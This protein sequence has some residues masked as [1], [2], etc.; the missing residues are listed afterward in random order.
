MCQ[1]E[2]PTLAPVSHNEPLIDPQILVAKVEAIHIS[3]TLAANSKQCWNEPDET[4]DE[5]IELETVNIQADNNLD[6]L[7]YHHTTTHHRSMLQNFA[8]A[9]F[10]TQQRIIQ[11]SA[12]TMDRRGLPRR[13]KRTKWAQLGVRD[14][15]AAYSC[16]MMPSKKIARI[17]TKL[18]TG[19]LTRKGF[20]ADALNR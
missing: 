17:E 16:R 6:R 2:G 4:Y 1:T 13:L 9:P 5:Q 12:N 20:R 7:P 11:N 14:V 10:H 18:R 15:A 8:C 3:N 19:A